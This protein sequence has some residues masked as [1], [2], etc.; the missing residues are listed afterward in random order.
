[1]VTPFRLM[2]GKLLVPFLITLPVIFVVIIVI[3]NSIEGTIEDRVYKLWSNKGSDYYNDRAYA[4]KLGIKSKSTSFLAMAK[5][6]DEQ[7]IFSSKRLD[8]IKQ[9][10]IETE[11]VTV[12]HKGRKYYWQDVCASNNLG[13]STMYKFPCFRL[14]PMDFFK[15]ANW[16]F[17]EEDRKTWYFEGIVKNLI[18]PRIGRV[19]T[20]LNPDQ[21]NSTC[22]LIIVKR[23]TQDKKLKLFSDVTGMEKNEKCNICVMKEYSKTINLLTNYAKLKLRDLENKFNST[24]TTPSLD[25]LKKI[26]NNINITTVEE[27][28]GYYVAR[29][30]LGQLAGNGYRAMMN[31]FRPNST[32]I[33]D[34]QMDIIWE[35]YAD[36]AFS[37]S[38]AT[39]G[40]PC[41]LFNSTGGLDRLGDL[42]LGGGSGIDL[43]GSDKQIFSNIS[44]YYQ[45][46]LYKW[47]DSQEEKMAG[48]CINKSP[49]ALG[50]NKFYEPFDEE[51]NNTKQHFA[52]MWY[53]LLIDSPPF[54]NIKRGES[55]PYTW[56][57][58][59]GCGYSLTGSRPSYTGKND[60]QLLEIASNYLYNY[61]EGVKIGAV[62]RNL[63]MGGNISSWKE[64]PNTVKVM[65]IIYPALAKEFI[66][67]RVKN[68]NRP[69]GPVTISEDDAQDILE[70][71][72][73]IMV[74]VWAKNWNDDSDGEVQFVGYFDDSGGATGTF[75]SVLNDITSDTFNMN[76][77]A[78]GLIAFVSILFL[79]RIN[80]VRSMAGI[81]L[82][83][84]SLVVLSFFSS[85]GF[86]VLLGIKINIVIAW[87]LPF[88][89]LGLG[90]D[91][92]Y[93]VLCALKK[94]KGDTINDFVNAMNDVIVPV[95]MT[96]VVNASM[97][98][99]MTVVN[100]GAITDTAKSALIAVVFLYLTIMFCFPAYCYLDSRRQANDRFDLICCVK[101]K[102]TEDNLVSYDDTSFIFKH[103]Y[104]PLVLGSS[105]LSTAFQVI[106]VL[107]AIVLVS[108][109][110]YGITDRKVGLGVED[111]F[112]LD[113]Q[114]SVWAQTRTTDLASWPVAMAW[115]EIDYQKP[116][117]QLQMM[118]AF[119]E[120]EDTKYISQID[121]S[122]LWI[123]DF[124]LWTTQ[125]CQIKFRREECGFNQKYD[126]DEGHCTG[127]W[128]KNIIGLKD[129]KIK[130][131]V[132]DDTVCL[133]FKG[134]VCRQSKDMHP[135]DTLD[136]KS[137][138]WSKETGSYCPVFNNW[139]EKKFGH[140]LQKWREHTGGGG[141]LRLIKGTAT[142]RE[143]DGEFNRDDIIEIPIRYSSSP[144]MYGINLFSHEDTI[145]LI[146]ETRKY[147]DEDKNSHCWMTGIP[148][149]FWE[150]YLT[151]DQT[152]LD[153]S[154]YSISVAFAVSFFFLFLQL[155]P[156]DKEVFTKKKKCI[157]SII[158]ALL[159]TG[160]AIVSIIPV[161]GISV[162]V[163]VNLTALSVMSFV[164][165]VGFS[166]EF[167]VHIVH[168]FLSAPISIVSATDRV[169]HVMDSL[170][171]PLTLSFLSSV[172]G[173]CCLAFTQ[174]KFN[175]V[176]FFRPLMIVLFVTY[177]VGVWL[178][179]VILTKLDCD[180][181]KVGSTAKP[182]TGDN[183]SKKDG[184][185]ENSDGSEP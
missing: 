36:S 117:V 64:N 54:L 50:C 66:P 45:I 23:F 28:Y 148:Y 82:V 145:S 102:E 113:H 150:Q 58:G 182:E 152:L 184:K 157:T 103:C 55:D 15:E 175:E 78:I 137:I 59:E 29:K 6:R 20:M 130:K 42:Q 114:A 49:F 72:K 125:Q 43:S 162:L 97:F 131:S 164:L 160:T 25:R 169:D 147:C 91:D 170:I 4:E 33:D 128:T 40:S 39:Y 92:M 111:F 47:F 112:P 67:D 129:K 110:V 53:N 107:G 83:G 62:D 134:G 73:E 95:T 159:I 177:F 26:R 63:L 52:K 19:G 141:N 71:F 115:G 7:N 142:K 104:K 124:N 56:T 69:G 1:M 181:L 132:T 24:E 9:R 88:V 65:Q 16:Y 176:Y 173:V 32:A 38:V 13:P 143:C 46:P 77:I 11:S 165:S 146:R 41:P 108:L 139:S 161:I 3:S 85:L 172:A 185:Q 2:T 60:T 31:K 116:K 37:S 105:I 123:A 168:R 180:F 154:V 18:I 144:G 179:P 174:Y 34:V 155:D 136:G 151:I 75:K 153:V 127:T 149:D 96:S 8:E 122:L 80:V 89:M 30:L 121:T 12:T 81:T 61:D 167:S 166:I 35:D 90:V 120:V 100:V 22:S 101:V 171:T 27:Y 119:E 10:M 5:S 140:C 70:K 118:K 84:V 106:I 133:P 86:G 17:T 99:I 163:G 48:K 68:C 158:G 135:V 14:S 93:I 74:D 87:T 98:A 178:L 156:F 94:R 21:C 126:E 44:T 51:K 79:A 57:S 76:A 138:D 109:G 183:M